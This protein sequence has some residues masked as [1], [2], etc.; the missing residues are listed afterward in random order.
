MADASRNNDGL[1]R[2]PNRILVGARHHFERARGPVG[3]RG[4]AHEDDLARLRA[5]SYGEVE[6][7]VEAVLGHGFL[8]RLVPRRRRARLGAVAE[9]L[10]RSAAGR[11]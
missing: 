4:A 3:G 1:R 5:G 2:P 10:C 9:P 7:R 6:L 11:R 8:W